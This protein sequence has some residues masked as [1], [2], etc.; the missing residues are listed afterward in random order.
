M[1][2]ALFPSP[3]TLDIP[4]GIFLIG[5]IGILI[6][7]IVEFR[8][9]HIGRPGIFINAI[10]LWQIFFSIWNTLPNWLQLY[11]NGG[12][13]VGLVAIIAY[14]PKW[15]LPK[16]FY[17]ICFLLYGSISIIIIIGISIYLKIPLI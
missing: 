2:P 1:I 7:G 14:I 12:S 10:L 11:I 9:G 17:Q 16:Q 8:R 13:I 4:K 15:K 6:A 5:L 3:L